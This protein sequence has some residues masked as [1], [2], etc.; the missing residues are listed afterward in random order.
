MRTSPLAQALRK[1]QGKIMQFKHPQGT[2]S[3]LGQRG[4]LAAIL[5]AKIAD[6]HSQRDTRTPAVNP[7]ANMHERGNDR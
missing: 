1:M 4:G 3:I 6:I 5:R 2:G 7:Y